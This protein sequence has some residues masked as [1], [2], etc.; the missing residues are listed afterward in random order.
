MMRHCGDCQLCCTLLPVRELG[1]G[2]NERCRHQRFAKGCAVYNK[3]TMPLPCKLWNC[4]WLVN[5]DADDLRRP[6]RAGYVVDI[7]PDFVR[8]QRDDGSEKVVQVVQIWCDPKRPKAYRDPALLAWLERRAR[9]PTVKIGMVRFDSEHAIVLWPPSIT[10]E[11]DWVEWDSDCRE[12][13]HTE[14]Q[15]SAADIVI[16]LTALT[17]R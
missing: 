9:E 16:A 7:V 11:A 13:M 5:D 15:H 8:M 14:P 1:K 6:D 4:R 3:P 2:A 12:E 17:E 10:G